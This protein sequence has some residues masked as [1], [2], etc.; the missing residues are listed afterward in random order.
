[1]NI[2]N[3]DPKNWQHPCCAQVERV[4]GGVI[5]ARYFDVMD[6]IDLNGKKVILK[7]DDTYKAGDSIRVYFLPKID[8]LGVKIYVPMIEGFN[9]GG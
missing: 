9:Y 6:H 4:D 5:T 2:L 7:A 1:M 3:K 8:R